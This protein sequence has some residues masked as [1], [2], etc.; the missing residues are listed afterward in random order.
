M[1]NGQ[2]FLVQGNIMENC[3]VDAQSGYAIFLQGLPSEDGLW[4][5]VG[6]VT[7]M[8]NIIRGSYSG[9][10]FCGQCLYAPVQT[11]DPRLPNYADPSL[12][13]VQ[14]VLFQN[15][16]FE[17]I[18][19]L[20]FLPNDNLAN[21]TFNH[22]TVINPVPVGMSLMTFDNPPSTAFVYENNIAY[23]NAYGMYGNDS[24][25]FTQYL[26]TPTIVN[27]VFIDNQGWRHIA[28]FQ[29]LIPSS[30]LYPSWSAADAL[31]IPATRKNGDYHLADELAVQTGR[32]G[33]T[34]HRREHRRDQL[35]DF[36]HAPR[37]YHNDAQPPAR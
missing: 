28:T 13:R 11:V 18:L 2:R 31:S 3:W 20:P 6:N 21:V 15:N 10:A 30:N 27:N 7:F 23:F 17:G 25:P 8:D 9:V 16:L 14:S 35:G 34:R 19:N 1:K 29:S 12:Q 4:V 32:Y 5:V 26:I 37:Q 36:H 22:N 33:W 24:V